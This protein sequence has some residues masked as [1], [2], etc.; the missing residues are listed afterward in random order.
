MLL[1]FRRCRTASTNRDGVGQSARCVSSLHPLLFSFFPPPTPS[2]LVYIHSRFC[3]QHRVQCAMDCHW[4]DKSLTCLLPHFLARIHGI[5]DKNFCVLPATPGS[6]RFVTCRFGFPPL[7]SFVFF[8]K[9]FIGKN[10]E[11]ASLRRTHPHR[12]TMASPALHRYILYSFQLFKSLSDC[13][14]ASFIIS[15]SF[16][17]W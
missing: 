1:F 17:N 8:L 15:I 16:N 6:F 3:G 11:S 7:F 14:P 4:D 2:L 10:W 12:S 5:P 9:L 13:G